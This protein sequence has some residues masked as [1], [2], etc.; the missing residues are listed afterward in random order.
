MVVR[1]S[2]FH[3]EEGWGGVGWTRCPR[4]QSDRSND[5]PLQAGSNGGIRVPPKLDTYPHVQEG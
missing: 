1:R 5:Q 2:H 3:T 4:F